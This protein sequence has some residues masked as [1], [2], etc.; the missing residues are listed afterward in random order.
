MLRPLNFFFPV[1]Y[2]RYRL[3]PSLL[4][5]PSALCQWFPQALR[6]QGAAPSTSYSPSSS[7]YAAA[8]ASGRGGTHG[9]GR[10]GGA[11]GMVAEAPPS[12]LTPMARALGG[13]AALLRSE[14]RDL[15]HQA[16]GKRAYLFH[17]I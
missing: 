9:W 16:A 3:A 10:E 13:T 14:D 6:A 17:V 7:S 1:T 11:G 8:A 12:L 5:L 4:T 2:I 15:Q